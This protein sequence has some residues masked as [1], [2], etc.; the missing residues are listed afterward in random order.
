M[1]IKKRTI[2]EEAKNVSDV[3]G[4]EINVQF[5][6]E[7]KTSEFRPVVY[8]EKQGGLVV[9]IPTLLNYDEQVSCLLYGAR[10]LFQISRRKFSETDLLCFSAG[11]RLYELGEN[12]HGFDYEDSLVNDYVD[13]LKKEI[14]RY[15]RYLPVR[16]AWACKMREGLI[17]GGRQY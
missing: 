9:L 15:G 1:V 2:H 4:M 11:Y 7:I 8:D 6:N 17:G 10:L 13:L 14:E 5:T 12:I 16:R 3:L